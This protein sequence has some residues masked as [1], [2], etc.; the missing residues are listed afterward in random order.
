MKESKR[1]MMKV[2]MPLRLLQASEARVRTSQSCQP[3]VVMAPR[4]TV[5][6]GSRSRLVSLAPGDV[7][8]E[9]AL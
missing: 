4:P 3:V 1:S 5:W 2:Q 6:A 9:P 8:G 7:Q